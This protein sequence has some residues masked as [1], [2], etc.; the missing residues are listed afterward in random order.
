MH[1]GGALVRAGSGTQIETALDHRFE[2]TTARIGVE[3]EGAERHIVLEAACMNL[4]FSK[5]SVS[6]FRSLEAFGKLRVLQCGPQFID[7]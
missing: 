5:V 2:R 3:K 6:D 1:K 4:S 7:A